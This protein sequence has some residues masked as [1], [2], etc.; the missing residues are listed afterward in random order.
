M[1]VWEFGKGGLEH[2]HLGF[3]PIPEQLPLAL[4]GQFLSFFS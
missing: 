1:L 4:L 2:L 3:P